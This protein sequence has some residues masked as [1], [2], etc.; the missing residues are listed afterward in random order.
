MARPHHQLLRLDTRELGEGPIRSLISPD[1]LA[2]REHRIAAIAFLVV[3]IGLV[4]MD[5]DFVADLPALDLAAHR[6][7]DAGAIRAGDMVFGLVP[8][9]RRN[10]LAQGCPD[11]VVIDAG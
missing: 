3:A 7:D 6:P 9:E 1:T 4:A 5:H 8:V 10:R 11:A 2:G